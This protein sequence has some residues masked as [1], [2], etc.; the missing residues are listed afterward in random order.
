MRDRSVAARV[1]RA[2]RE[3]REL[4]RAFNS[5][6]SLE[7]RRGAAHAIKNMDLNRDVADVFER[8]PPE[9]RRAVGCWFTLGKDPEMPEEI[10]SAMGVACLLHLELGRPGFL[11]T[12]CPDLA[13]RWTIAE[14][15]SGGRK[16]GSGPDRDAKGRFLPKNPAH[17]HS[18]SKKPLR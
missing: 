17:H 12:Y 9:V 16:K 2:R 3:S 8:S 5:R 10:R 7:E 1:D 11:Q 15:K 6:L 14:K 4:D 13:E 18:R